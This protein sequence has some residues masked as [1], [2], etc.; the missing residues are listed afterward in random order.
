MAAEKQVICTTLSMKSPVATH[1]QSD[2]HPPCIADICM[3]PHII[4]GV[5]FAAAVL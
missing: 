4:S 2:E 3:S 5:P 1:I